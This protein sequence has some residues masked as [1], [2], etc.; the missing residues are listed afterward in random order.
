MS[1]ANPQSEF[2]IPQSLTVVIVSFN[3]R[4]F[5]EQALRSV[6]KAS[7]GLEVE[8]FVVDNASSD[9]SAEMVRAEH[10]Q[11]TLHANTSNR[12]YGTAANQGI[13]SCRALRL[14]GPG[15]HICTAAT[16]WR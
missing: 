15:W 1:T 2:R 11:V 4:Y 6:K 12:G 10:P 7:E 9:G 3:V 13:A 5:L 16:R 8:V 14:T